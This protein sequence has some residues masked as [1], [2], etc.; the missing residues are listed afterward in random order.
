MIERPFPAT[1]QGAGAGGS[2]RRHT[3]EIGPLA[4]G[5]RAGAL[6]SSG[7]GGVCLPPESEPRPWYRRRRAR[8]C[9]PGEG[10]ASVTRR[11]QRRRA[12]PPGQLAPP[13]PPPAP[14]PEGRAWRRGCLIQADTAGPG[15]SGPAG[16]RGS[17]G[18]GPRPGRRGGG[19]MG[20][21]RE[22]L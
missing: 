18:G 9:H 19:V 7:R 10:R 8:G 21:G 1:T 3:P 13:A 6:G 16:K 15:S 17:G 14:L 22:A 4:R 2:P 20:V 12:P 5:E 11:A